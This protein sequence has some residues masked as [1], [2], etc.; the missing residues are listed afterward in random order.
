LSSPF[1]NF[2]CRRCLKCCKGD[3]LFPTYQVLFPFEILKLSKYL[4]IYPFVFKTKYNAL[5]LK[6]GFEI[7]DKCLA[8]DENNKGCF[9]Q[10]IKPLFCKLYPLKW[11]SNN[12]NFLIDKTCPSTSSLKHIKKLYLKKLFTRLEVYYRKISNYLFKKGYLNIYPKDIKGS[13]AVFLEKRIF[14]VFLK[15]NLQTFINNQLL[16]FEKNKNLFIRFLEKYKRF[17]ESF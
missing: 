15:N 3:N 11:D 1:Y 2:S 9:I 5:V 13:Y 10:N 8:L 17:L 12:F 16:L 6:W 4:F 14:K 7:F